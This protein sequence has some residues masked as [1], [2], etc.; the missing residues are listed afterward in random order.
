MEA[1]YTQLLNSWCINVSP[2]FE[3][4]GFDLVC[5]QM[6]VLIKQLYSQCSWLTL[7]EKNQPI[8]PLS[9]IKYIFHLI[10]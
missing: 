9:E 10:Q 8:P 3:S 4:Q 2:N 1:Q 5:A 6:L 7:A